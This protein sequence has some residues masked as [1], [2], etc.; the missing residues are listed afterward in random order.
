MVNAYRV[1]V[2]RTRIA[3][4]SGPLNGPEAVARHYRNLQQYDRERLVRL[5]L[6]NR[7]RLIGEETVSIGTAD[8]ALVSPREVFKG[9]ILNSASRIIVLHNHPSGDP[10]PSDEDRELA[11]RLRQ[12][13]ELLAVPLID[14]LIIGEDGQYCYVDAD[15]GEARTRQLEVRA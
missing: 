12:V 15:T 8:A 11:V 14:F 13:G 6:D 1:E 4:P 10:Q 2:I 9:A 7:N 5:D 3:E